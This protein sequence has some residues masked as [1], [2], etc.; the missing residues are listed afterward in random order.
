MSLSDLQVCFSIQVGRLDI[1]YA[2]P[3]TGVR[4]NDKLGL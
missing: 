3:V 4:R 1:T 2:I